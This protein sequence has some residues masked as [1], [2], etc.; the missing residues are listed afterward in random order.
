MEALGKLDKAPTCTE[1]LFWGWILG[2]SDYSCN[3]LLHLGQNRKMKVALLP[4]P[5]QTLFGRE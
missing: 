3:C 1:W 5:Q 2:S 4:R